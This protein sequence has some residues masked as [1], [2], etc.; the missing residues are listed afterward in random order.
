M[1]NF[2]LQINTKQTSA[3]KLD[4]TSNV[5]EKEGVTRIL[6]GKKCSFSSVCRGHNFPVFTKFDTFSIIL[7][8]NT[9]LWLKYSKNLH[10]WI[11]FHRTFD[12]DSKIVFYVAIGVKSTRYF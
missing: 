1:S 5:V 2:V 4:D 9:V 12:T 3:G 10:L 7:N 6:L 8:K 11:S